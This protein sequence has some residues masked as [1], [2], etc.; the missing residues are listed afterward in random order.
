[1]FF[2]GGGMVVSTND[3]L[4]TDLQMEDVPILCVCTGG[5]SKYRISL[6]QHVLTESS[7]AIPT[8]IYYIY[9]LISTIVKI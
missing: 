8:Y 5:C 7:I 4:G 6:L 9:I 3:Y 1:M 2:F